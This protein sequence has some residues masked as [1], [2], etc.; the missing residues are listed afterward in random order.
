MDKA[1][2]KE[3]KRIIIKYKKQNEN[4]KVYRRSRQTLITWT[5]PV[6]TPQAR[7]LKIYRLVLLID[8]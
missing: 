1:S 5:R 8:V 4:N 6:P 2:G 3:R 7:G